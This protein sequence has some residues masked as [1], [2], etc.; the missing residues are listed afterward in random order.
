MGF[1]EILQIEKSEGVH[2][3]YNISLFKILSQR[4]SNMALLVQILSLLIFGGILK[5]CYFD[6]TD[7]NYENGFSHF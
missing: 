3:N 2:S 4:N 6:G 7:L 1:G 5:I